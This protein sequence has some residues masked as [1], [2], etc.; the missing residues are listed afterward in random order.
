MSGEYPR[1]AA[2][3]PYGYAPGAPIQMCAATTAPRTP[4]AIHVKVC[5]G[6]SRLEITCGGGVQMACK[7]MDL[8]LANSPWTLVASDGQ[9][10]LKAPLVNARANE[11]STDQKDLVILKGKVRL[12]YTTDGECAEIRGDRVEINFT[13]GTL[14][15]K[16]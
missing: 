1:F 10:R 14:K 6:E 9:V 3:T 5:E 7:K 8:K 11:I 2:T 13:D 16:P 4:P 12:S 15:V